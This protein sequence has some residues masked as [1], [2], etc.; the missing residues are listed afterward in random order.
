MLRSCGSRVRAG[1]WSTADTSPVEDGGLAGGAEGAGL[2]WGLRVPTGGGGVAAARAPDPVPREAT[3]CPSGIGEVGGGDRGSWSLARRA[4]AGAGWG[5]DR[6][7]PVGAPRCRGR[8]RE[9][10][11]RHRQRSR[12]CA[13][14]VGWSVCGPRAW[15]RAAPARPRRGHGEDGVAIALGMG[16]GPVERE[17]LRCVSRRRGGG[18]PR[19]QRCPTSVR[20]WS[21][22]GGRCRAARGAVGNPPRVRRRSGWAQGRRKGAGAHA[23]DA[24]GQLTAGAPA[25][26][27]LCRQR[28]RAAHEGLRGQVWCGAG[29]VELRAAR[30]WGRTCSSRGRRRGRSPTVPGHPVGCG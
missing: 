18:G 21:A 23:C 6:R 13:P 8:R 5:A 2:G 11:L 28:T 30:G 24:T 27:S 7:C 26:G 14:G 1:C 20:S 19:A 12:G 22:L 29:G 10:M 17:R 9:A 3:T 16:V 15:S 4:D 25:I